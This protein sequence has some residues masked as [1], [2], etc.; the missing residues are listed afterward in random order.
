[1]TGH[2]SNISILILNVNGFNSKSKDRELG[3]KKVAK[4]G[5]SD[6]LSSVTSETSLRC[7]SHTW[8]ILIAPSQKNNHHHIRCR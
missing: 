5:N 2:D 8:V 1:M 6:L 7:W 4:V 3:E